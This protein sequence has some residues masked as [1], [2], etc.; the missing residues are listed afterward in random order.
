MG[1]LP[2]CFFFLLFF[3]QMAFAGEGG[4]PLDGR[5]DISPEAFIKTGDSIWEIP[6]RIPPFSFDE[7]I[8]SWNAP[9]PGGQGFRLYIKLEFKDKNTSPWLYGGY[10]GKAKPR[11]SDIITTFTLGKI[12]YDYIK[13]KKKARTYQFRVVSEG[14][15]KLSV[16]PSIRFV[17]TDNDPSKQDI[18]EHAIRFQKL[19]C[20]ILDIPLRRQE[21]STGKYI[22]GACQSAAL[23]SAL[24]YY[25]KEMKLEDIVD[26]VYDPEYDLKGI[27]PRT[28]GAASQLGFMG[29]I[30]RF[31][32]WDYVKSVVAQ[33]KVILVSITMPRE[34]DYVDP[35]YPVMGGHIVALNGI[36]DDGRVVVT[37]SALGKSGRGYRCQWLR[38][39]FVKVWMQNKGGVGMVICPPDGAQMKEIK[40]LPPFESY[41]NEK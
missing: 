39:D 31:R 13:L 8:Y 38:P 2:G 35:P 34:G 37:D 21:D 11:S 27:W 20:P 40:N 26:L 15:I 16:L 10:W 5:D 7:A 14:D 29:Y 19:R 17:Y 32:S 28:I 25:G 24:E 4:I 3:H 36:T 18:Q 22:K 23:A 9:L 12:D 1:K 30:D 6:E 33:N 41:K